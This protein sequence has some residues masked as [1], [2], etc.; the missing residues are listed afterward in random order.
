MVGGR[1]ENGN[2]QQK[3]KARGRQRVTRPCG[4]WGGKAR[5]SMLAWES[6]LFKREMCF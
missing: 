4:S 1:E 3:R 2:S 5:I 6:K